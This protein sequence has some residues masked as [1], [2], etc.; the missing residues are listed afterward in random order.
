MYDTHSLNSIAATARPHSDR[1]K[2]K[3]PSIIPD[4]NMK[5]CPNS[6]RAKFSQ[7]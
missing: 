7:V 6:T 5:R 4:T 2:A 3:R 1:I